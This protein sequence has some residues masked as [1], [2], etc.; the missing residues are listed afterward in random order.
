L[1]SRLRI[2]FWSRFADLPAEI[3]ISFPCC[4]ELSGLSLFRDEGSPVKAWE[5]DNDNNEVESFLESWI[6]MFNRAVIP[7][8]IMARNSLST[9]FSDPVSF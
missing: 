2:S 6:M 9:L 8:L 3:D 4:V 5:D 1:Q 7:M